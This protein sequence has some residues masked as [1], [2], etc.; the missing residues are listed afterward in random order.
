M[1]DD[2]VTRHRVLEY[3]R[4]HSVMTLSTTGADGP[5]AAAVFYVN[6]G[7]SFYFLSAAQTRHCRNI[8]VD[9]RVAVT[10][11]EDY[12]DYALIQG[13]QIGAT[14]RE[15]GGAEREHA[16]RLYAAKFQGTVAGAGVPA[17]L[18]AALLRVR[19]YELRTHWIRFVDN[20]RGFGHRDEWTSSEVADFDPDRGPASRPR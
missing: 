16:R 1:T 14:S 2:Q 12:D 10:I 18:A 13:V 4:T 17:A 11:Q 9:P 19:W 8:A 6:E 7:L 15:L 3:L 20:T 5:A